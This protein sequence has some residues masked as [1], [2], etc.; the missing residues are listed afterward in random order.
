MKSRFYILAALILAALP[1]ISSCADSS[2]I[3]ADEAIAVVQQSE[4]IHD[5]P[6]FLPHPPSMGEWSASYE[7]KGHWVAT[8]VFDY[9]GEPWN[10]TDGSI[11]MYRYD[12]YEHSGIVQF[13]D[14]DTGEP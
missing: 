1:I 10:I 4:T 6:I 5:Y 7:D 8:C 2:K 14:V 9:S 11:L 12:Y 13:K 3:S